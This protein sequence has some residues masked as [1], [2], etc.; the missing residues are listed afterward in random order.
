MASFISKLSKECDQHQKILDRS[1]IKTIWF[2]HEHFPPNLGSYFQG[3]ST[4]AHYW[5]SPGALPNTLAPR[6]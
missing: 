3:G 6:V 2:E 4:A 5:P 1:S